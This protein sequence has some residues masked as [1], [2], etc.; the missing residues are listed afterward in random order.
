VPELAVQVPEGGDVTDKE[1]LLALLKDFGIIGF[2]A[3]Q[4]EQTVRL[5][6]GEGGVMG[7]PGFVVDFCFDADGKFKDVGVWE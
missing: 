7:S 3:D 1:R 5:E 6:A 2:I 4:D